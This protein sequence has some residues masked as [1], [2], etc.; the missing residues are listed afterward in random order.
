MS[1]AAPLPPWLR[2]IVDAVD[3]DRVEQLTRYS[4]PTPGAGRASAVLALFGESAAG[5]DV[6]LIERAYGLRNHA[7]TPAFPGGVIDPGD[8]GPVAAALREAEEETGLDPAGVDVLATLPQLWLPAGGYAVTPVLAWW[9]EPSPVGVVDEAEVAS[10]HRVPLVD[11]VEPANRLRVRH[12][13][14]YTGPAFR[15]GGLLVWGFTAG[16]LGWLLDVAGL[17]RPWDRGR[18]EPLPLAER[19]ERR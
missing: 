9:S 14:G 10:V 5:S 12:P 19:V 6:L 16:I 4:P 8:D 13:S 1:L 18:V 7:G 3:E 2:A 17:A 15:V 11:L